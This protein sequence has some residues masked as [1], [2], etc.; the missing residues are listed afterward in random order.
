VPTTNAPVHI[1][2]PA[3]TRPPNGLFSVAHMPTGTDARFLMGVDY[4][5]TACTPA[6][7][8]LEV[9]EPAPGTVKDFGFPTTV[10]GTVFTVVDG[11]ECLGN[12]GVDMGEYQRLLRETFDAKA[13]RQAEAA[14]QAVLK[15][16]G[17]VTITPATVT[18]MVA[19][20]EE[21]LNDYAGLG[22]IHVDPHT[23]VYLDDQNLIHPTLTGG[24]QTV[25]GTPVVS[26]RGYARTAGNHFIG[27][28]GQV[29]VL[30]G[31]LMETVTPPGPAWPA[32][33]LIE[34]PFAILIEC[35]QDWAQVAV[36]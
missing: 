15:A 7:T 31:P 2:A 16:E 18:E 6:Q 26:G 21:R 5:T 22:A 34:Q 25:N 33:A 17:A 28:T 36:A 3:P 8:W 35:V 19:A 10:V 24:L 32:R 9:C 20:M 11:M 23:A 29:T 13:E 4:D 30:R 14:L 1:D 27:V 12:V